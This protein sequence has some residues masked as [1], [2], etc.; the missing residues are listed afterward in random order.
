MFVPCVAKAACRLALTLVGFIAVEA[1]TI[2]ERAAK[3]LQFRQ[4]LARRSLG[5]KHALDLIHGQLPT[6]RLPHQSLH[7]V[8]VLDFLRRKLAELKRRFFVSR[9]RIATPERALGEELV[10]FVLGR[11]FLGMLS[12]SFL[13]EA[14]Y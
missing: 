3:G 13:S 7:I 14:E 4:R 9:R 6:I 12:T 2:R 11:F 10:Y 8:Q 1:E 5:G